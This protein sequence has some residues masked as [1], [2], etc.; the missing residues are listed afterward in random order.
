MIFAQDG[1]TRLRVD[2]DIMFYD[3]SG[4]EIARFDVSA[5]ALLVGANT[6][7]ASEKLRVD[8]AVALGLGTQ[9]LEILDAGTVGATHE[10]W[11]EVEIGGVVQYI[12]TYTN[13]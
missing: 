6:P 2:A 12:Q 11:I 5:G 9:N 4:S 10:G 3:A 13:K 7:I 1:T 8:G